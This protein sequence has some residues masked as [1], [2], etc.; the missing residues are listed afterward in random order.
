MSSDGLSL[1]YIDVLHV[2][3]QPMRQQLAHN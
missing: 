3:R 1:L 2:P